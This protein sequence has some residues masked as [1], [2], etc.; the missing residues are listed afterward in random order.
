MLSTTVKGLHTATVDAHKAVRANAIESI[1]PAAVQRVELDVSATVFAGRLAF[2][3]QRKIYLIQW[4]NCVIIVW[5]F[6]RRH[7]SPA[8]VAH[9]AFRAHAARLIRTAQ[10]ASSE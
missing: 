4:A 8:S 6:A 10:R 2:L 7:A 9:G 3:P 5:T 1:E